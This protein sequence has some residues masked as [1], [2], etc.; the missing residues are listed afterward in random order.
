MH[1]Y[2][3]GSCTDALLGLQKLRIDGEDVESEYSR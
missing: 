3:D 1:A 2:A